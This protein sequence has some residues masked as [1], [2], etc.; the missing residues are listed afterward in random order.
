VV[1][2]VDL[3]QDEG[4]TIDIATFVL[5]CV[6]MRE[7]KPDLDAGWDQQGVAGPVRIKE[8]LLEGEQQ[9]QQ[10]QEE[11]LEQEVLEEEDLEG[12]FHGSVS[13]K[14]AR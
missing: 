9:Q 14:I 12:P 3:S 6:C 8:E 7:V 1:E 10:E 11:V 5:D 2:V 4:P 13:S